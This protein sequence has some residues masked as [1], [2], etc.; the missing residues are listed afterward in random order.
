MNEYAVKIRT[1][2]NDWDYLVKA[3]SEEEAERIACEKSGIGCSEKLKKHT[4]IMA[5]KLKL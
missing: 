3:N 4:K 1:F 5:V 2:E